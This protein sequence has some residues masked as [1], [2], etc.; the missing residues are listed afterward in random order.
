MQLVSLRT[1]F[2]NYHKRANEARLELTIPFQI[3]VMYAQQD[4]ISNSEVDSMMLVVVPLRLRLLHMP[5]DN[6]CLLH[7]VDYIAHVL[8]S[9]LVWM[10]NPQYIHYSL[11]ILPINQL[12]RGLLDRILH[13]TVQIKLNK[14]HMGDPLAIL[15]NC[16]LSKQLFNG[17]VLALS[18]SIRL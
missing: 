10:H 9:T 7:L 15:I 18:L 3:D 17:L 11:N 6:L 2:L 14:W 13:G 12:K 16:Y 4:R 8:L 1:H 5:K